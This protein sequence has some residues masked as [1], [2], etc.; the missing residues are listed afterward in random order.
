VE[1]KIP[2]TTDL[3]KEKPDLKN[4]EPDVKYYILYL[5]KE[6]LKLQRQIAKFQVSNFSNSN[7]IIAM[8]KEIKNFQN[9][10]VIHI[11][12]LETHKIL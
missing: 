7:K 3:Y 4:L 5:E 10:I 1:D 8:E 2:E 12:Y 6:N 9:L 11:S